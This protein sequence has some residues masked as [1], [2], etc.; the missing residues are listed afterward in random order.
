MAN[1][2]SLDNFFTLL[3]G[4]L[5]I[6]QSK[7]VSPTAFNAIYNTATG[8]LI[9]K[10]VELW[11]KDQSYVD[12]IEPFL[13]TE[14]KQVKNGY[15]ELPEEYRNFLDVG[16]LVQNSKNVTTDCAECD[17]TTEDTQA[18]KKRKYQ[19]A[20][21]AG[22]CERQAIVM[23]DQTQWD[24]LTKDPFDLPTYDAPI[25]CQFGDR[26]IKIC[27]A[28]IQNVE[29]RYLKNEKMYSYGYTMQ[30]DDTFIFN[31]ATSVESEWTNAAFPKLYKV[32]M[33]LLGVYLRDQTISG[34]SAAMNDVEF[35]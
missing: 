7:T 11:P 21:E 29:L 28:S 20:I 25:C 14:I 32:C 1:K 30:P 31:A 5:D 9:G 23:V 8:W 27:P 17:D 22:K 35:K 16:A 6:P 24:Y 13:V 19:Q 12:I 18:I 34:F 26:K 3:L 2:C 15:I 4:P 10:I 33:A